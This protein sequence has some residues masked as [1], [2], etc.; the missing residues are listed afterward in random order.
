MGE[1]DITAADPGGLMIEDGQGNPP[2]NP[3]HT[4]SPRDSGPGPLE[5]PSSGPQEHVVPDVPNPMAQQQRPPT[6]AG[7]P[8]DPSKPMGSRTF[9][10]GYR[11]ERFPDGTDKL[12]G[13]DGRT[14]TW[15][16]SAGAWLGT[17]GQPMAPDWSQGHAPGTPDGGLR[18]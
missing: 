3:Y 2:G 15:D 11:M 12:T 9:D 14:A 18:N 7:T 5:S 13:T 17:D 10:D 4:V 8:A 16:P 1:K 6:A